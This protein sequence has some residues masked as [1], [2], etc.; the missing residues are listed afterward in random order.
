M[1]QN[2]K[3]SSPTA[4]QRSAKSPSILRSLRRV[5]FGAFSARQELAAEEVFGEESGVAIIKKEVAE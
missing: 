4:D 5:L 1:A 3:E 2:K